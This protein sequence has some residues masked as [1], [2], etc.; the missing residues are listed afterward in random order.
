MIT[1]QQPHPAAATRPPAG[2]LVLGSGGTTAEPKLS[3][4]PSHLFIPGILRCWNPLTPD[5]VLVNCNNGSELGSMNPFFS[6]LG[7]GAGAVALPLGAVPPDHAVLV[8]TVHADC[9]NPIV[10]YR[11]GDR[12][13]LVTCPCGRQDPALRVLGRTDQQVKFCSALVTPEEIAEATA[14]D[15]AAVESRVHQAVLRQG[16]RIAH[17]IGAAAR[18]F[19][20]RV[21]DRLPERVSA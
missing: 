13:E 4:I 18:A 1:M 19:H 2:A 3:V 10:R 5:G 11:V 8:T 20:V 6:M 21:V 12:G 16:Y 9:R 17:E 7:H 14:A 15:R